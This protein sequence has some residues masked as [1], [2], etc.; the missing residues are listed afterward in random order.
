M[1]NYTD[2][3]APESPYD[4]GKIA[5][6]NYTGNDWP[7][8]EDFGLAGTAAE[9]FEAGTCAA[10]SGPNEYKMLEHPS[11]WPEKGDLCD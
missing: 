2:F 3:T 7:R 11:Y 4:L 8:P 1:K 10:L 6:I 9:E 5:K